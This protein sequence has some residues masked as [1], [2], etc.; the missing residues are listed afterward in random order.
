MVRRE[1]Q[2]AGQ[3]PF[4]PIAVPEHAP[5]VGGTHLVGGAVE[6]H[7][8]RT[9]V[10]DSP[11]PALG[12]R[13]VD[14]GAINGLVPFQLHIGAAPGHLSIVVVEVLVALAERGV[15]VGVLIAPI[16]WG[17]VIVR[18]EHVADG[19]VVAARVVTH[20]HPCAEAEVVGEAREVGQGTVPTVVVVG[21]P[22]EV[23]TLAF[24]VGVHVEA[25]GAEL[26]ELVAVPGGLQVEGAVAEAGAG[27]AGQGLATAGAEAGVGG[28]G[29]GAVVAQGPHI[30]HRED[31]LEV[32]V[33]AGVVA[34]GPAVGG[35]HLAGLFIVVVVDF[36]VVDD[37]LVEV[38]AAGD[39]VVFIGPV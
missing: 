6:G 34:A 36:L 31:G 8:P 16:I 23:G 10:V 29:E 35:V 20:I 21:H 11:V 22:D 3:F 2:A 24:S 19:A 17:V 13:E 1:E 33:L 26:E 30:A 28:G 18:T 4:R 25:I 37:E 27:G 15:E 14:E 9:E 7:H 12:T 32:E 38:P 5:L 39:E